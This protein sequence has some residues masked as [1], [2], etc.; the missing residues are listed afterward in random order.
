[1]AKA[2]KPLDKP[3]EDSPEQPP[4]PK[5]GRPPV[6]TDRMP[7][8]ARFFD[9]MH[10]I[11]S[12]DWL[13]KGGRAVVKVYRQEPISDRAQIGQGK[14]IQSYGDGPVDEQQIK[15]NHGSG[16]YLLYLNYQE[17]AHK[18]ASAIDSLSIEIL[19][20][21]FPP[22]MYEAEWLEDPRNKRW[23][24]ARPFLMKPPAPPTPPTPPSSIDSMV[25]AFEVFN[26]IEETA[27]NR[28][29]QNLP[30]PPATPAQPAAD[31]MVTALAL[32]EKLLTI[33]ADNPMVTM[34][35]EQLTSMRTELQEQRKRADDLLEKLATKT[36]EDAPKTDA[37]TI[38]KTFFDGF[39]ELREQAAEILPAGRGRALPWWQETLIPSVLRVVEPIAATIAQNAMA[40][41]S[42][43]AP[44]QRPAQVI[45]QT[46]AAAAQPPHEDFGSFLDRLT[47]NMLHFLREYEDESAGGEFAAW[48]HDGYSQAPRAIEMIKASG[49][50]PA[51]M[52]WYRTSKHWPVIGPIEAQFTR[53]L[54]DAV[55]WKPED[56]EAPEAPPSKQ[57]DA[58]EAPVID[59]D[60]EVEPA[61]N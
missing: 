25:G 54:T 18:Q 44:G 57:A 15:E 36:K 41:A 33:R 17:P 60:P 28:A 9:R 13:G 52:A 19:D 53:F 5:K 1:M 14:M 55:N 23:E 22:K 39:K 37:P 27:T 34:M 45:Q 30:A 29:K 24:W 46:P 20:P 35:S 2:E 7:L 8:I 31:P 16:K 58:A 10:A 3:N 12:G 21:Q 61:H 56:E 49:G 59:L 48:F 50:V 43:P 4:K 51:L 6:A 26:K 11:P 38:I 47:P 40:Q 42:Q 32:A